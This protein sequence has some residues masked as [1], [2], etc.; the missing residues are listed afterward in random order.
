[1]T[2]YQIND[3]PEVDLHAALLEVRIPVRVVDE[4]RQ[5]PLAHLRSS[6]A[7]DEQESIYGIGLSRPIWADNRGERLE[8]GVN[9]VE[10]TSGIFIPCG[11][12]RFPDV[13]HNS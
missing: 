8:A 12:D 5:F 10:D 4:F 11:K 7:K 1:M 6:I 9:V 3:L 2:I 13:Q